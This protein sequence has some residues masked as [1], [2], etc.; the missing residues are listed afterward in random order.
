MGTIWRA[1]R[2]PAG[3]TA[4]GRTRWLVIGDPRGRNKSVRV[5]IRAWTRLRWQSSEA[6]GSGAWPRGWTGQKLEKM[7]MLPMHIGCD[8]VHGAGSMMQR[9]CIGIVGVVIVPRNMWLARLR[10]AKPQS[11]KA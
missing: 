5:L 10:H 1:R 2:F 6:A 9:K 8:G 7:L 11:G 4:P 3:L